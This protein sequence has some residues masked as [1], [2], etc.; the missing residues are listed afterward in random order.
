VN[1]LQIVTRSEPGGAQSVVASLAAEFRARGHEVAVVSGPEGGGEAWKGLDP[2][3]D[4]YEIEGLLRS[5]SPADEIRALG[6]IRRL[7]RGWRPDIVQLHTSKAGALGRLAPG[8]PRGRIVYTMHG[9]DQLRVA[10]RRFLAVDKGL[11]RLCG[12]VVAVSECDRRAMAAEGYRPVLIRNGTPDARTLEPRDEELSSRLEALKRGGLPLVMLVARDAAPKRV[13]LARAAAAKL[14]G[15]AEFA[16]I[17]GEPR[18]GDL[19]N[20]HALGT[21]SQAGAYLRFADIFLLLSDHEGL[22]MGL[23]EAFSAGIP[24]VTSAVGG[25]L[26]AMGIE[27]EGKAPMGMAVPNEAGAIAA[28][29]AGLASASEERRAMGAAARAAW[30]EQYSSAAMAEGYLR[31][32]R[33]LMPTGAA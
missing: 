32:Y 20:F 23:L 27:K 19:A 3:I 31:L 28:A 1:I 2:E 24:C 7:Y 21:A 14:G 12:A 9:F 25:C 33:G 11:R 22:S 16:W 17:G 4:L 18:P 15:A 30:E 29:I 6:A 13:D 8:L 26:E 5:V 10:N